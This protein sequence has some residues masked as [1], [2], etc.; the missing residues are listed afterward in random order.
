MR[1]AVEIAK[2]VTKA[3][4]K[5]MLGARMSVTDW[6]DGGLSVEEGVEVARALKDAGV[7]LHL[8]FQRRQFAAAEDSDRPRLPGASR[9]SGAQGGRHPGPR[10]RHDRRRAGRPKTIVADGRADM[11]ALA[12]AILADPR[13][14]WR[15]AATL[16]HAFKTAP[17][18]ARAT[19]LH[20]H[21][22]AG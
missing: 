6:V 2:A 1:L 8:L 22:V 12:R 3:V 17:Q 13:W 7:D 4:P 5:L 11:V 14:P 10:R 16:G 20:K 9:R 15:A 19:S 21:W 18:L